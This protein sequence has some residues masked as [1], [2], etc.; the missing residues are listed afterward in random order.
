[1]SKYQYR[2]IKS[3]ALYGDKIKSSHAIGL[4]EN[5]DYLAETR[6]RGRIASNS[7]PGSTYNPYGC[8]EFITWREAS[9]TLATV[10]LSNDIDFRNRYIAMRAYI[11]PTDGQHLP[12]QG[13]DDLGYGFFHVQDQLD[14]IPPTLDLYYQGDRSFSLATGFKFSE[15]GSTGLLSP[16][17]RF[18]LNWDVGA[19]NHDSGIVKIWVSSVDGSLKLAMSALA[20]N[21]AD[22]LDMGIILW[23]EVSPVLPLSVGTVYFYTPDFAQH[24]IKY[25]DNPKALYLQAAAEATDY[26][27]QSC[28]PCK[29]TSSPYP[30]G[31]TDKSMNG[32]IKIPCSFSVGRRPN[33]VP[34]SEGFDWRKRLIWITGIAKTG[35]NEDYVVGSQNDRNLKDGWS[36]ALDDYPNRAT[37]SP[38][39]S[40]ACF[41]SELGHDG[42][43]VLTTY[44][45]LRMKF[46]LM[47]G[48]T[49]EIVFWVS[50]GTNTNLAGELIAFRVDKSV[51]SLAEDNTSDNIDLFMWIEASPQLID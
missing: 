39:Y 20:T 4:H 27:N 41:F 36:R 30:A 45:K 29:I 5:N 34:G 7:T 13:N 10:E 17:F 18:Q 51:L 37:A 15:G 46:Q 26:L 21:P 38:V 9:T 12:G 2:D 1:M 33:V 44:P 3:L 28:V 25:D 49:T 6:L 19:V 48:G 32:S 24:N 35:S 23:F 43:D 50:D 31:P 8:Y 14:I 16:L 42:V 40:Q 22:Q 47:I 11:D